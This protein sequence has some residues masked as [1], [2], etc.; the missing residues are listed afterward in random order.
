[1]PLENVGNV[2]SLIAAAIT[3]IGTV[4]SVVLFIARRR[5][6]EKYM[7]FKSYSG[8]YFMYR[9]SEGY[10]DRFLE[11]NLSIRKNW[12]GVPYCIFN[13][14][15]ISAPPFLG[16]VVLNNKIVSCQFNG[17]S[18]KYPPFLITMEISGRSDLADYRDGVLSGV[19]LASSE[20]Y[21]ARVLMSKSKLSTSIISK[22]LDSSCTIFAGYKTTGLERFSA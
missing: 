17:V 22:H 5:R 12:L 6:S 21:C 15:Y 7:P 4:V 11:L 19:A 20:P 16:K 14:D 18:Q 10:K 8:D 2:I 3:L 9:F 1:M 13:S